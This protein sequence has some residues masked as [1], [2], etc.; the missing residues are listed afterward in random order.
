[1]PRAELGRRLS[2]DGCAAPEDGM[3]VGVPCAST[4]TENDEDVGAQKQKVAF[5]ATSNHRSGE[6]SEKQLDFLL[7]HRYDFLIFSDLIDPIDFQRFPEIGFFLFCVLPL[8]LL[9][10]VMI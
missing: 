4:T 8:D 6:N 10:F 5:M 1:M 9:L 7:T 3:A 2:G